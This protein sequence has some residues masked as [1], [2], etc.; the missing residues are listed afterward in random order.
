MAELMLTTHD[1]PFNPFTEFEQWYKQDT[2]VLGH[3]TC[4]L[5]ARTSNVS[6]IASDDVNNKYIE[7]AMKKIVEDFPFLYKITD[8]S[9]GGPS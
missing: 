3:N 6:D 7:D 5:L 9:G 4:S 1:N 2:V 8:A